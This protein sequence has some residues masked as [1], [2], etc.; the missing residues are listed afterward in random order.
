MCPPSRSRST[1]D[2]IRSL[3][4]LTGK[5][6]STRDEPST[7]PSRWKYPTPDENSTTWPIGKL[8]VPEAGS[9]AA[10]S[11]ARRREEEDDQKKTVAATASTVT[12]AASTH[13]RRMNGSLE[14]G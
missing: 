2:L 8:V 11:A 10:L 1:M 3:M 6:R 13:V 9:S 5:D 14:V 7:L 12:P 4:S